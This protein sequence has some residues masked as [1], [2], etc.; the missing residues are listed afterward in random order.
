MAVS[1]VAEKALL[2][3]GNLKGV[4]VLWLSKSLEQKKQSR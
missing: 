3:R 4:N 1:E 2:Q